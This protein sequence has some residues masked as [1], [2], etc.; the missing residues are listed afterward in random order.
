[1]Y[2]SIVLE[3]IYSLSTTDGRLSF[4]RALPVV[5]K[6]SIKIFL[7]PLSVDRKQFA[8]ARNKLFGN[9]HNASVFTDATKLFYFF[10]NSS[11]F[12]GQLGFSKEK[13]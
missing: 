6:S 7:N 12:T 9:L 11:H 1:M 13:C 10:W 8:C 3:Q 2:V 5:T 4:R